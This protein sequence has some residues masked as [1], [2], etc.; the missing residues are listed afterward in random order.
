MASFIVMNIYPLIAFKCI[1]AQFKRWYD[2]AADT[3]IT[4]KTCLYLI[5]ESQQIGRVRYSSHNLMTCESSSTVWLAFLF[6][7]AFLQ[8]PQSSANFASVV[9][10]QTLCPSGKETSP[11][12][13]P[14]SHRCTGAALKWYT[15]THGRR[16]HSSLV[17]QQEM[18]FAWSQLK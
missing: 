16:L 13:S 4:L 14:R 1:D 18:T 10:P 7:L 8:I 3:F 17:S 12:I 6:G 5:F 11:L 2:A 15:V 9:F